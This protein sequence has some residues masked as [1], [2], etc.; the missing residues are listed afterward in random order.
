[1]F[2]FE[3]K[4][5][6]EKIAIDRRVSGGGGVYMRFLQD[7]GKRGPQKRK[8]RENRRRGLAREKAIGRGERR[9]GE[10]I[11]ARRLE[12]TVLGKMVRSRERED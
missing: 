4:R 9:S 10:S 6:S 11:V 2:K 8:K 1:M 5:F 7:G 12:P 3:R